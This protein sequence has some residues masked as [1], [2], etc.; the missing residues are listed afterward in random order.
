MMGKGVHNP[1][2]HH[3]IDLLYGKVIS[4]TKKWATITTSDLDIILKIA[5]KAYS[6][7][8]NPIGD[9]VES[10]TDLQDY[11]SAPNI[12]QIEYIIVNEEAYILI[13]HHFDS[14][15]LIDA[16]ALPG[17]ISF[18]SIVKLLFERCND[19][20]VYVCSRESTSYKLFKIYER[21]NKIKI[22]YDEK[23]VAYGE[24][25]H[26]LKCVAINQVK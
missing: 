19:K 26:L 24:A 13:T 23:F 22:L 6:N 10:L 9:N 2:L 8:P 25:T 4:K 11:C 18:L 12:S 16:G 1:Y 15:V 3:K 17:T 5:E 7:G 20:P 21:R 14:Y